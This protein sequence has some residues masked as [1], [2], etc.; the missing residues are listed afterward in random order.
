MGVGSKIIESRRI[1]KPKKIGF[2]K[3]ELEYLTLLHN[4]LSN[5]MPGAS[6]YSQDNGTSG[7]LGRSINAKGHQ[8]FL[9]DDIV[10]AA[11]LSSVRRVTSV[12]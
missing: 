10:F 6:L 4:P 9:K 3:T 5:T 8:L 7:V 12:E 1:P 2:S 11:D